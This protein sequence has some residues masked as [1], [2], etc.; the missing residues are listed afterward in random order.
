LPLP[1]QSN[2]VWEAGRRELGMDVGPQ[3]R[4]AQAYEGLVWMDFR[5]E[6]MEE[7]GCGVYERLAP[8][9]AGDVYVAYR[10]NYR[11]PE[12]AKGGGLAERCRA[13]ER[14]V[15]AAMATWA[16]Y[17]DVARRALLAAN[18]EQAHQLMNE[19]LD[20]RMQMVE[21][22][23]EDAALARAARASAKLAGSG[24]A[25]VGLYEGEAMLE[26][27]RVELGKLGARVVRAET[28]VRTRPEEEAG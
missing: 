16:A 2:L 18:R 4:L 5:R 11:E 21:A 6:F 20:L 7:R 26:R 10:T 13:G 14:K 17:A 9:L 8:E 22:E 3:G 28:G 27:L 12:K 1:T 23:E 19:N 25:I 15:L 24:G